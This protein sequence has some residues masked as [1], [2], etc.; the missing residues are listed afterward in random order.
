MALLWLP[1]SNSYYCWWFN[2]KVPLWLTVPLPETELHRTL[3][4]DLVLTLQLYVPCLVNNKVSWPVTE[5][6]WQ[7]FKAC[8][9]DMQQTDSRDRAKG[10]LKVMPSFVTAGEEKEYPQGLSSVWQ[11][12]DD[13]GRQRDTKKARWLCWSEIRSNK[14]IDCEHKRTCLLFCFLSLGIKVG[15]S[16]VSEQVSLSPEGKNVM[17]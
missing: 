14:G 12:R 9:W 10:L 8:C 16:T 11:A 4:I 15:L 7:S 3:F 17:L 6:L 2:T 13:E 1:K 5:K